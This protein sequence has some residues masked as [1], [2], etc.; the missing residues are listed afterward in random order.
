MSSATAQVSAGRRLVAPPVVAVV[1]VALLVAATACSSPVP[2]ERLAVALE[3]TLARSFGFEVVLEADQSALADLGEQAGGAAALLSG[4]RLHGIVDGDDT[5]V[6]LDALGGTVVELRQITDEGE[7]PVAWLRA[8]VVD[9]LAQVGIDEFDAEADL[10]DRLVA[11]RAPGP[12]LV[13][14]VDAFDGRWIGIEGGIGAGFGS[15]AGL[16]PSSSGREGATGAGP[17]PAVTAFG[18]DLESF[19]DR[20]VEVGELDDGILHLELRLSALLRAAAGFGDDLGVGREVLPEDLEADLEGLPG[21]VPGDVRVV[22][23]VVEE[24]AFDV[25]AAAR[26]LGTGV[27]GRVVLRIRVTDHGR[28]GPVQAPEG[29]DPIEAGTLDEAVVAILRSFGLA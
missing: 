27:D 1:V 22:D 26:A 16:L 3:R 23:G 15:A 25:A 6:A 11:A 8:G 19:L 4:I 18:T 14:V 20:F 5:Q 13:A 17:V 21:R 12:L 9:L 28:A 7:R 29:V 10:L 24:L 2:Q